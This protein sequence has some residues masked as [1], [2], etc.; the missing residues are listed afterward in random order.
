MKI[1][2]YILVSWVFVASS[3]L[4]FH[5]IPE[6]STH[7]AVAGVANPDT[8]PLQF[9]DI[10]KVS[11]KAFAAGERLK[12]NINYGIV[13]AGEAIMKISD[14]I[15][16]DRRCFKI[17]FSLHSKPFFDIFY[18]VADHY[19]TVMDSEGIFPWHF[20]QHIREGGYSRDFTAEF[21]QLRHVAITSEGNHKIP[22]YVHDI[23]SAF[24]FA[25]T[26][27]Y[28]NF[29]PGQRIHLQNFYKDSTYQL[30]V[31]Y[32]GKQT[33][34]VEAGT[35]NCIIV[36]PLVKEGGL[37]KGEGNIFVWLTDDDRKLPIRVNSKI[38]IGSIDSELIEYYG[39]N[40][41]LDAKI[42]KNE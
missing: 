26:V 32:R 15:M 27:D 28:S 25:R 42:K 10:R 39:L 5:R 23:M 31:R 13:T 36:E 4:P 33:I 35:F 22:P 29:K 2:L 12:F 16:H 38:P 17:D 40:G 11:N 8:V 3:G 7:F 14:T 1:I 20:E 30:D 24:Y 19:F 21:D 6:D 37:F 34:E 18:R 9:Q 41:G